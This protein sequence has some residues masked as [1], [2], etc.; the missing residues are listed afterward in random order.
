M[1]SSIPL[2]VAR[3]ACVAVGCAL[4][5]TLAGPQPARA[6]TCDPSHF[7]GTDNVTLLNLIV[8]GE[9]VTTMRMDQSATFWAGG[10]VLSYDG[11]D[12]DIKAWN[13]CTGPTVLATSQNGAG[14]TDFVI[15]D[16]NNNPTGQVTTEAYCYGGQCLDN[17]LHA[18]Y[19]WRSG[20]FMFVDFPPT[21][22]NFSGGPPY[23]PDHIMHVWDVFLNSGSTYYFQFSSSL[24]NGSKM[25]LFRN[26]AQG[27]YWAGRSSAVFETS[28]CTSYTAPSSG[29]Y[30]LVVVN[31][32]WADG[33]YTV[34][35]SSSPTCACAPEVPISTPV[36][37]PATP[38]SDLRYLAQSQPY[39][40]AVGVRPAVGNDWDMETSTGTVGSV[41][42]PNALL[43]NSTRS[44]GVTDVTVTDFNFGPLPDSL[45]L[46]TFRFSGVGGGA[47]MEWEGGGG[48]MYANGPQEVRSWGPTDVLEARDVQLTAGTTYTFEFFPTSN[49][50]LLL[51]ANPLHTQRYSTGRNGAV[52]TAAGTVNYTAPVSGYY[53][54]VVVK[55]D[56]QPGTFA[57]RV[58][59][60]QTPIALTAGIPTPL[61]GANFEYCTIAATGGRWTAVGVRSQSADWDVVQ[62][63]NGLGVSWP[64]CYSPSLATSDLGGTVP[65]FIVGYF[66]HNASGVYPLRFKQFTSGMF[67]PADAEWTGDAKVLNVNGP[68]VN[69]APAAG[70]L[71]RCYEAYLVAG[72]SYQIEYTQAATRPLFVFGHPEGI[73][74]WAGRNAAQLSTLASTAFTPAWSGDYGF[75]I[76]NDA[77]ETGS[78]TLRVRTTSLTDAGPP[79]PHLATR[80]VGA[81]P[82]PGRA[83]MTLRYTLASPAHVRFDLLDASGRRAWSRDEGVRDPGEWMATLPRATPGGGRLP[84]GLYFARFEVDGRPVD[85]RRVTLL[86]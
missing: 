61:F 70:E 52:L 12:Y 20:G 55:D 23:S 39:W 10:A 71:L 40:T 37:I 60:C 16:F 15:G 29:Y 14:R 38:A 84:A 8:L 56:D 33:Q 1:R 66:H 36:A 35:V 30:G 44:A 43:A 22:V 49:I 74:Y 13:F 65:D 18:A 27:T 32:V 68:A 69:D 48:V 83:D 4:I 62:Y 51:F 19:T 72:M 17:S 11:S 21:T 9:N 63:G 3:G 73:D 76:A 7:P 34:G 82:N 47:T 45:A 2:E 78:F 75:V 85:V 41:G 50:K 58:G 5:V 54:V 31:D 53:G 79:A 57:L 42:C 28:G 26:A 81:Q 25:L 77:S 46:H 64:D 6:V 67:Q 24:G 86:D 80:F 59:T